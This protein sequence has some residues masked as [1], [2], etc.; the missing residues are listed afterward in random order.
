[1]AIRGCGVDQAFSGLRVRVLGDLAPG[2]GTE[3]L[4][5]P[6]EEG[7]IPEV[8]DRA[9]G[10]A[11]EGLFGTTVTA[12]GRSYGIDA[13]S[14]EGRI[15]GYG[16]NAPLLPIYFAVPD[17]LCPTP[18]Q[19]SPRE[20]PSAAGPEGDLLLAGG[21]DEQ[22]AL[23]DELVHLDLFTQELRTL[24]P[25][26]P[27]PRRGHVVAALE[28]RR[29]VIV[30]GA[31]PDA[32]LDAVVIA[33][34]STDSVDEVGS[35]LVDGEPQALSDPA[36]ASSPVDG[37]VLLAGG[38]AEVDSQA[39]CEGALGVATWFDPRDRSTQRLPD[40]AVP[41]H[42]AHALVAADGVAFVAGGF[43]VDGLA[44]GSVE[45]LVPGGAWEVV[46]A[47]PNGAS[48][49]GF[50]LLDGGLILLAEPSGTIH[51]W[52][53]AGSGSLDPTSRAP[54]LEPSTAPR[55]LATL[56]GERV[57]VDGW[58]FSPATAAV[59]P[60]N[61]RIELTAE[62]RFG[63]RML[64]LLDGTVLYVGGERAD[65]ELVEAPL[66]RLRPRLDGPD[67][68]IPELTGP[69]TDAFV[70]NTPGRATV[71]VGGL[72]LDAVTGNV[73][74]LPPVRAH[75]RGFRSRSFRL[76]L[77]LEVDPS[78]V[79]HVTLEQGA[80]ATLALGLGEDGVVA[81]WRGVDGS[82]DVLDC[83]SAEGE[84]GSPLVLEVDD[85][86]RRARLSGPSGTLATCVLAWPSSA[87]LA[88]GF[89]VSGVGSARFFGLRL[90]RR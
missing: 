79:A 51:W 27:S 62:P 61:E 75:V 24:D 33:D 10:I 57:L 13:A 90:A 63:A 45:R 67:E 89:G 43:D 17:S 12:V 82:V 56:P 44:L 5:G 50:T 8:P 83:G 28:G 25:S 32:A 18:A 14:A 70:T 88:V 6:G 80:V 30:G 7:S 4:L 1:M 71:I 66:W 23:L 87:G 86:G 47:L 65:A 76:E 34:V 85:Q 46:H 73:D 26:L 55:P 3:L 77:A 21:I 36:A 29:F 53:E 72:R 2:A 9:T 52:S 15:D 81:R 41:R 40:L 78:A 58:L 11:A 69:Q 37:R 31:E 22:G 74:A 59:D 49:A 35:L 19:P 64:A 48:A 38:C 16:R 20:S 42:S 39:R 84:I 68:W 60:A 54:V